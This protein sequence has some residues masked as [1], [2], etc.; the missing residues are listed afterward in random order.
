MK[1]FEVAHFDLYL[2]AE[3]LARAAATLTRSNPATGPGTKEK[4]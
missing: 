1:Y 4:N 2:T 3:S